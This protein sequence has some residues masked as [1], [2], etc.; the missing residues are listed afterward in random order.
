MLLIN[1]GN[2][3]VAT[4]V[5]APAF[6]ALDLAFMNVRVDHIRSVIDSY[7]GNRAVSYSF[8]RDGIVRIMQ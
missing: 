7:Y 6:E 8:D 1:L 3:Q 5:V 2:D 4:V